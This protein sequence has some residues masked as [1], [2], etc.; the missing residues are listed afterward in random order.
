MNRDLTVS[1]ILKE[2][3]AGFTENISFIYY[4]LAP[5]FVL[6]LV[7]VLLYPEVLYFEGGR[8]M[9]A[10][11]TLPSLLLSL[12]SFIVGI[13]STISLLFFF[14]NGKKDSYTNWQNYFR[15]LPKYIGVCILQGLMI[16]AG[17]ILLIVPGIYLAV[18]YAFVSY[19]TLEHPTES[20]GDLFAAEAKATEGNRWTIFLIGL[21]LLIIAMVFAGIFGALFSGFMTGQGNPLADFLFE[22]VVTPFFMVV[23][24]LTYLKL[25]S[26]AS[27]EPIV[28]VIE[29]KV[30]AAPLVEAVV[31]EKTVEPEPVV[32]ETE[33]PEE[34]EDAKPASSP[35][36]EPAA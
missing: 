35:V 12:A 36:A 15:L 8:E 33:A 5:M 6:S 11:K 31:E 7:G 2:S 26:N 24:I 30:T 17:L 19:R 21:L 4:L 29:E 16:L 10:V 3:W 22:L 28:E 13:L 14:R 1:G 34:K 25:T 32:D 20:I 23:S 18:R 9:D 27:A